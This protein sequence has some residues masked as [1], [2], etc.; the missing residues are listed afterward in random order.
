ML[1]V[2]IRHMRTTAA[3]LH[4]KNAV[5]VNNHKSFLH[6]ICEFGRPYESVSHISCLSFLWDECPL[7]E[8]YFK[9]KVGIKENNE[10]KSYY[11]LLFF[12]YQIFRK[13]SLPKSARQSVMHLN[14]VYHFIQR[15]SLPPLRWTLFSD[16][17]VA[18]PVPAGAG[19]VVF[20][21]WNWTKSSVQS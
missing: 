18:T 14:T 20:T 12:V 15:A 17:T 3:T 1:T 19:L 16:S 13:K 5:A 21:T 7:S 2:T 8:E 4:F 11:Y 10:R 9:K 6:L